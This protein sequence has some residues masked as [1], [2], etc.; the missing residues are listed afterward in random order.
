MS[1]VLHATPSI[2]PDAPLSDPQADSL[3]YAPLAERIAHAICSTPRNQGFVLAVHGEWGSG[4]SSLLNFV[5]HYLAERG[6]ANCPIIVDFN[7]WWFKD[8]EDLAAQ[9]LAQFQAKLIK[10][11]GPVRKV[12]D[13]LAD[14]SNAIGSAVVWS[15]PIPG[16]D[17]VVAFFL[18]LF[19][20]KPKSVPQ[21][22]A[23]ISKALEASEKRTVF[24]VDDIDRLA[25]NEI[26]ELFKVIK[27]LADF[28]NVTYLLAFDRMIVS[29]ALHSSLGVDGD[30]YI[31]KI[32]QVPFSLPAIDRI[33]LRKMLFDGLDQ[34]L[35]ANPGIGLDQGHWGNVYFSGLD[36]FIRHPRDVVR[37]ISA[38]SVTYPAV[39]GEV[40]PVDFIAIEILRI[41]SPE[42]YQIIRDSGE[43]FTKVISDRSDHDR[44]PVQKFH[45]TWLA[46]IPERSRE[47]AKALV[48]EL[49]PQL[50]SIVDDER[51]SG[52]YSDT[53]HAQRRVC[54]K[55]AF[56]IYFQFG[57]PNDQLS[58]AE[59]TQ[60]IDVCEISS[61]E[62]AAL[63]MSAAA[64]KRLD[65]SSKARDMLDYLRD[66]GD[67]VSERAAVGLISALFDVGDELLSARDAEAGG[68]LSLP[69]RWRLMFTLDHL[70]E[71]IP[72]SQRVKVLEN[73]FADGQALGLA[74]YIVDTI[75]DYLE[76]AE[77]GRGTP[78][79]K[80][81]TGDAEK[82]RKTLVKRLSESSPEAMLRLP[83]FAG[84]IHCWKKWSGVD[85]VRPIVQSLVN[86][87]DLLPIVLERYL[88]IGRQWGSGDSVATKTYEL[89]PKSLAEIVDLAELERK[90]LAIDDLSLLSEDQIKAVEQFKFGVVRYRAIVDRPTSEN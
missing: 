88:S 34:I 16:L 2:S 71:R 20:R 7:P 60:L 79:S 87:A 78:L 51:F 81:E 89:N 26:R 56:D 6:E 41:K 53:W 90:V 18:S 44:K 83:D 9:F 11:T 5:K 21:L 4:K 31:E 84:L 70:L 15:L 33:R 3:G 35:T 29:D 75:D 14:Y 23:K 65:G 17:K 32:V 37:I 58:R 48:V 42:I 39:A 64:Q 86:R 57:V 73:V 43:M 80:I 50:S 68:M 8:H 55:K 67:E 77:Q 10:E 46:R 24:L 54:S 40:N 49:F 28:P 38:I 52:G 36:H 1:S 66:L 69:N 25:P 22:K 59:L 72:E 45:E 61:K 63:L 27:A 30:A 76:K 85:T 19:K 82:L 74:V 12:G 13:M 62:G 47:N